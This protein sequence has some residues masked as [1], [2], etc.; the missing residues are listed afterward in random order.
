MLRIRRV[1]RVGGWHL[2]VALLL[3]TAAPG[4]LVAQVTTD[5]P[6]IVRGSVVDRA[7]ADT[8]LVGLAGRRIDSISF[9]GL[10]VT[11]LRVVTR[12]IHA[13]VGQPLQPAQIGEDLARLENLGIFAESRV[14][15][16]TD[17]AGGVSLVYSFREM[18]TWFP[19][20]SYAYTE[21]NGVAVGVGLSSVNF[22]GRDLAVSARAFFGG[23][24]QQW[25]R[26]SWPWIAGDHVSLDFYGARLVRDDLLR[27]FEETSFEFTP[28]VGVAIGEHAF[29]RGKFS[30]FQMRS[31]VTGITLG[32]DNK[33]EVRRL[34]GSIVWDTRDSWTNP[35]RGIRHEVELWRNG[36]ILGGDG[37]WLSANVDLRHW[38][39]VQ[40]RS[41][42][43]LS[44]LLSLQQGALGTDIP[45][46]MDYNLGG[47]NSIRGYAVTDLGPEFSG[48]N[49]MIGTVE[50]A[51]GVVPPRRV[52]VGPL[53]LRLGVE[54]AL[55]ADGSIA[56]SEPK[57]FRL[58]RARAGIGSGLRLL[59]PGTEMSRFD[60]GWSPTGGLQFHFGAGT[61]MQAQRARVR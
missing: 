9:A 47:A 36:G 59:V 24:S 57:E 19:V 6:T 5:L 55:F 53:S 20:A 52:D 22:T 13:A 18:P 39:P 15:V 28:E 29:V 41:K 4:A 1:A 25:T 46:Y 3:A 7:S 2:V 45:S 17:S 38:I 44:G 61:K 12:E 35:R 60:F 56:W 16:E 33:D 21:E 27:G 30:L 14:D 8:A 31:D 34:G 54:L 43:L 37:D 26:F 49:Q 32:A 10:R 50:Y 23:V 42:I 51:V 40:R 58:A 48:K 11:K